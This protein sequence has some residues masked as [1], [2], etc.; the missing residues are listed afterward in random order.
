MEP[1]DGTRN[2][3]DAPRAEGTGGRP[4]R[5]TTATADAESTWNRRQIEW[6]GAGYDVILGSLPE[7]E[8]TPISN[9]HGHQH[10]L[11][12]DVR[13][14][15]PTGGALTTRTRRD[16]NGASIGSGRSWPPRPIQPASVAEA[17]AR[18]LGESRISGPD[19]WE[20]GISEL[21]EWW[22]LRACW[23]AEP[24]EGAPDPAT[25]LDR[26]VA[27]E[28]DVRWG[29]VA[30][31]SGLRRPN[32]AQIVATH[33]GAE[34]TGPLLTGRRTTHTLLQAVWRDTDRLAEVLRGWRGQRITAATLTSW[35]RRT[36]GSTWGPETGARILLR[37]GIA[38][39]KNARDTADGRTINDDVET[40]AWSLATAI[41]GIGDIEERRQMAEA[42]LDVAGELAIW[43]EA[44]GNLGPGSGREPAPSRVH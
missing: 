10:P 19:R 39:R 21:G 1:D 35:V 17:L 44:T 38:S 8:S 9:R 12:A 32:G 30:I 13:M 29:Q 41:L 33:E 25:E 6:I 37:N 31:T 7:A 15:W 20:A 23:R 16:W 42:I 22:S 43:T 11:E 28:H 36:I 4:R 27:V 34:L 40:I 5:A 14:R 3:G 24:A 2:G 18:T 26:Y